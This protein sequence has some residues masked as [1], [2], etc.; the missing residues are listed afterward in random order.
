MR[1]LVWIG[2]GAGLAV[3]VIRKGR[4]WLSAAVPQPA[5]G[6]VDSAI[7]LGRVARHL[8]AEFTAGR[9]EKERELLSALVGDKDVAELRARAPAHRAALHER[10]RHGTDR[11][12]AERIARDWSDQPTDDPDD[13]DG[14][15]FF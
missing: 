4:D 5:A 3:L 14:Y 7:S 9:T 2:I 12:T 8:K 11:R 15:A 1:R 10:R 13:D 6:A